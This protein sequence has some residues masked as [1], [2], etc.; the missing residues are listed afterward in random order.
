MLDISRMTHLG[1][2]KHFHCNKP[3]SGRC[4]IPVYQVSRKQQLPIKRKK[5]P[6]VHGCNPTLSVSV[7]LVPCQVNFFI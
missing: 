5:S 7:I 2:Q 1:Q 3:A 4:Y 6:K